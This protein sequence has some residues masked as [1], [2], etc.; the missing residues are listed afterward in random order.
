MSENT[1]KKSGMNWLAMSLLSLLIAAAAGAAYLFIPA[2]M[3]K[4]STDIV[5]IRAEE[6]PFKT[7]P[8][9]PGGKIITN[10]DSKVMKMLGDL[11]PGT[12]E[13]ET[14][15]PPCRNCRLL[16]SRRRQPGVQRHDNND[17]NREK[18]AKQVGAHIEDREN[19]PAVKKLAKTIVAMPNR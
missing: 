14:L 13:V 9:N 15:L 8:A 17:T 12:E 18:P 1:F 7:K 11:T 16:P 19:A 5:M 6:G 10:Q 2:L 4:T 3:P